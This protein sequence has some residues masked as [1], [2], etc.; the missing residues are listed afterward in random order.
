MATSP[1][2]IPEIKNSPNATTISVTKKSPAPKVVPAP[3]AKKAKEMVSMNLLTNASLK[4][5]PIAIGMATKSHMVIKNPLVIKNLLE[6]RDL[7]VIKNLSV[8]KTS[9]TKKDHR[10]E[11]PANLRKTRTPATRKKVKRILARTA[12]VHA[13]PKNPLPKAILPM[14]A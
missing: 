1:V 4:K 12:N 9:P 8:K 3:T 10:E 5:I 11:N 7:L 14:M 13:L 2:K 6:R